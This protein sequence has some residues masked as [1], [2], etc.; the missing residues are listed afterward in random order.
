M[1]GWIHQVHWGDVPTWVGAVFLAAAALVG[2]LQLRRQSVELGTVR[3]D[4]QELQAEQLDLQLEPERIAARRDRRKQ[5]EQVLCSRRK[6]QIRLEGNA[7]APSAW[8]YLLV[9]NTS[10]EPIRTVN[11]SFGG[12]GPFRVGHL[13]PQTKG[14]VLVGR[15]DQPVPIIDPS[16]DWCFLQPGN[17]DPENAAVLVRFDDANEVRWQANLVG[18]LDEAHDDS[19]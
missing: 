16:V 13:E 10:D 17:V 18:Q 6:D 8:D 9:T 19:W 11:V 14:L 3:K 2:L 4:L 5:A 12:Q 7:T 15:V 1:S